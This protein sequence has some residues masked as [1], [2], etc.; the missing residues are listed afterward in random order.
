[1]ATIPLVPEG[2]LHSIINEGQFFSEHYLTSK[3][4]A[5]LADMI[6]QFLALGE[7]Y[8]PGT[9]NQAQSIP[10]LSKQKSANGHKK[11]KRSLFAR[12]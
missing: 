1:M 10:K 2:L 9:L 7:Y 4:A 3:N 5:V 11:V 12:G 6:T 8:A